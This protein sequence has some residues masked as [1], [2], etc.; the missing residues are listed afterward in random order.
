MVLDGLVELMY[1]TVG[2]R[3]EWRGIETMG[4]EEVGAEECKGRFYDLTASG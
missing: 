2:L 3:V 4:E 1:W